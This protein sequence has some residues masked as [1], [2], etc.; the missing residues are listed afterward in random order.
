MD[1]FE[2]YQI[3]FSID[4]DIFINLS[5]VQDTIEVRQVALR[6]MTF[7]VLPSLS[8]KEMYL[9]GMRPYQAATAC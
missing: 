9:L 8:E 7:S 1:I 4:L 2:R 5:M 3:E 6:W